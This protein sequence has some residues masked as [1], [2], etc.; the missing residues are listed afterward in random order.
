MFSYHEINGAE[1]VPQEG[2][3]EINKI[4]LKHIY[5]QSRLFGKE[6]ISKCLRGEFRPRKLFK[7][8]EAKYLSKDN[9]SLLPCRKPLFK[10]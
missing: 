10:R 2:G 3:E 1:M 5:H 9:G 6:T 4:N 8:T 7:L